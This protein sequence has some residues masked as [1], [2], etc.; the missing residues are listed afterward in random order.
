MCC[1]RIGLGSSAL[2]PLNSC[3]ISGSLPSSQ[4]DFMLFSFPEASNG[5]SLSYVLPIV[6]SPPPHLSLR[7]HLQSFKNKDLTRSLYHKVLNAIYC[8]KSRTFSQEL[9][10]LFLP[11]S[12]ARTPYLSHARVNKSHSGLLCP[13]PAVLDHSQHVKHGLLSCTQAR[14][15]MRCSPRS[16]A[17]SLSHK[18]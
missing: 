7:P 10:S 12:P 6:P 2:S 1:I 18:L 15:R 8:S 11:G 14:M 13:L 17:F 4:F 5:L 3:F 16:G 9:G